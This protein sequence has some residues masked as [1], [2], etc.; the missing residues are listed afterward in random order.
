MLRPEWLQDS[1]GHQ[2]RLHVFVPQ[3]TTNPIHPGSHVAAAWYGILR[4]C[5][6]RPP[7]W[8]AKQDLPPGWCW[9]PRLTFSEETLGT[10]LVGLR[11]S[12]GETEGF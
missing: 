2:S 11:V 8:T 7:P 9:G 3:T 12:R 4:N 5:T 6:F 10:E 1:S